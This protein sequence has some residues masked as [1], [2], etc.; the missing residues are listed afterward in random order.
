[1]CS[2]QV[3]KIDKSRKGKPVNCCQ[4]VIVQVTVE[5]QRQHSQLTSI[6]VEI[7]MVS[8]LP[9]TLGCK[10]THNPSQLVNRAIE[11]FSLYV[12]SRVATSMVYN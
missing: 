11:N 9:T 10:S 8:S 5:T 7:T 2:L 6:A 1:M 3:N 12:H 4:L